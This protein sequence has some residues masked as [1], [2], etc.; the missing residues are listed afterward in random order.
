M[1]PLEPYAA[2][3]SNWAA[4]HDVDDAAKILWV[5]VIK[6]AADDL[7]YIERC[8]GQPELKQY[9]KDNLKEIEL[10]CSPAQFIGSTW[11][12][13]ICDWLNLDAGELRRGLGAYLESAA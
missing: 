9:E 1:N 5:A 3:I 13:E 8:A 6:K 4:E 11:F 12:E 7:V 10:A 2:E